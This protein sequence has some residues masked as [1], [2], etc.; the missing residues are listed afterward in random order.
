MMGQIIKLKKSDLFK[1][2]LR[3]CAVAITLT[4]SGV[5]TAQSNKLP[6]LQQVGVIP[7]QWDK[8]TE[9]SFQLE[10]SRRTFEEAVF[11]AAR[12]AR[13]FRILNNDLVAGMWSDSKGREELATQFE[14]SAYLSL[15]SANR[16][17]TLARKKQRK[18]GQIGF[19]KYD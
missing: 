8:Q 2:Q 14:L 12:N 16:D 19:I 4:L 17:E 15:G 13:R 1:N 11:D 7:V 18:A 10:Q 6:V 5:A 9:S 3:L